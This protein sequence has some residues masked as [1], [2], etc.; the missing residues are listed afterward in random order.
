MPEEPSRSRGAV[1][2][3]S[4]SNSARGT[5]GEQRAVQEEGEGNVFD[6]IIAGRRRAT[7][8]G[9]ALSNITLIGAP[10]SLTTDKSCFSFSNRNRV[11][12]TSL[13]VCMRN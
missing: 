7:G 6:G 1:D 5:K 11:R 8:S 10:R 2:G 3:G 13:H 9:Q 4:R 12:I